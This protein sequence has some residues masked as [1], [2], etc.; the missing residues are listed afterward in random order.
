MKTSAL[1][2]SLSSNALL[3]SIE[4][5]QGAAPG[6]HKDRALDELARLGN[7]AQ[8]VSFAP[9]PQGRLTQRYSR[10]CGF[11]ANYTF[12]SPR[13]AIDCLLRNSPENSINLRSFEPFRPQSRSFHYGIKGSAEA[14]ALAAKMAEQ[15]LYVIA[16]ETV[17]VADGGVSG[18]IQGEVIEFAPDDTP[19]CVEKPG[20]ASLPKAIGLN[21]LSRVYGF[22]PDVV[23]V[24]TGR[25]EFSVH[26]KPRG[27]KRTHTIM[28]ERETF[29]RCP[30]LRDL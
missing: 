9:G 1:S 6:F 27:W 21:L 24:G 10:V 26:P 3:D 17:D 23:D 16:N 4:L 13:D 11:D 29:Q 15:S 28:W 7:V 19:R 2:N 18:V 22:R 8:F 12:A 14:A 25:L 30:Q 20:A 5:V